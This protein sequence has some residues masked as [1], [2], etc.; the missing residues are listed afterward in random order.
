[1]AV[2]VAVAVFVSV[3]TGVWGLYTIV[4]LTVTYDSRSTRIV[5]LL[6]GRCHM[7]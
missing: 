7:S 6:S 5:A 2:R 4:L 1:M 3:G